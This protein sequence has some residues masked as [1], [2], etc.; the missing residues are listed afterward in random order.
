MNKVSLQRVFGQ[1]FLVVFSLALFS[2]SNASG[3]YEAASRQSYPTVRFVANMQTDMAAVPEEISQ[4][5]SRSAGAGAAYDGLSRSAMPEVEISETGAQ[6]YVEAVCG[7]DRRFVYGVDSTLEIG[8]NSGRTWNVTCGIGTIGT[9]P[10]DATKTIAT[11][12]LMSSVA[13]N[14]PIPEDNPIFSQ[15][16]ALTPSTDGSGDVL[17]EVNVPASGYKVLTYC[18][19]SPELTHNTTSSPLPS[20]SEDNKK[21]VLQANDVTSGTYEVVFRI[22]DTSGVLVYCTTQTINVFDHMTTKV[23]RPDGSSAISDAGVFKVDASVITAFVDNTIYVG[24]TGL[25]LD[26]SDDNAGTAFTPLKKLNTA[27]EKIK[28]Y[29]NAKDYRIYISGTIDEP[30][31]IVAGIDTTKAASITIEGYNGLGADGMPQD[32]ILGQSIG[33]SFS[34]TAFMSISARAPIITQNILFT[35]S[36]SVGAGDR[37]RALWLQSNANVTLGPGTVISGFNAG[38]SYDSDCKYN[39]G[40]VC[41]LAGAKLTVKGAVISRNT[42]YAGGGIYIKGNG[43]VEIN[44]SGSKITDNHALYGGGIGVENAE[45]NI[46]KTTISGNKADLDKDYDHGG[47]LTLGVG[48]DVTLGS[49]VV[50]QGNTARFGG[51]VD[52]DGATLTLDGGQ[53]N[54]NHAVGQ[55]N[56]SHGVIEDGDDS[57]GGCG[58]GIYFGGT[59]CSVNVYRG[60]I[61]GNTAANLGGGIYFDGNQFVDEDMH[62]LLHVTGGTIEN[63]KATNGGGAIYIYPPNAGE[64][65]DNTLTFN[66]GGSAYIPYGVNGAE[67]A[68]KN[69]IF[70]DGPN[71]ETY[72][73]ITLQSALTKHSKNKPIAIR[74]NEDIEVG[75]NPKRGLAVVQASSSMESQK[76][77]FK[78]YSEDWKLKLSSDKTALRLDA[79]IYVAGLTSHPYCGV[80]GDDDTGN[81]TKTAPFETIENG[82]CSVMDDFNA[83]YTI[84]IDGAVVGAQ[85]IPDTALA[86]SITL[87]GANGDNNVDKIGSVTGRPVL[88][89]N[90]TADVTIKDLQIHAANNTNGHGGDICSATANTLTLSSGARLERSWVLNEEC[91]GAGVYKYTGKLVMEDGAIIQNGLLNPTEDVVC[92]GAGI[93]LKK[94]NFV[95]TGGKIEGNQNHTVG[96][97]GGIYFDA[98]GA[99]VSIRISGGEITKNQAKYGAGIYMNGGK[100][101]MSGG[102]IHQNARYMGQDNSCGGGI[103]VDGGA[104]IYLY[105]KA[106]IGRTDISSAPTTLSIN[107]SNYAHF[108]GGIYVEKGNVWL[109]YKDTNQPE[110]FEEV[111]EGVLGGIIGNYADAHGGGIYIDG[112][113]DGNYV[114]VADGQISYN[115]AKS[116]SGFGGGIFIPVSGEEYV[117]L[118]GG[119]LKGNSAYQGG[120]IYNGTMTGSLKIGGDAFIQ[121]MDGAGKN[122]IYLNNNNGPINITSALN[123]HDTSKKINV[124]VQE[125]NFGSGKTLVSADFAMSDE[126]LGAFQ[127]FF[128]NSDTEALVAANKKSIFIN[129]PIYV[130]GT[131]YDSSITQAGVPDGNGSRDYP[132]D[133][134]TAAFNLLTN[135][136]AYYNI[137]VNGKLMGT[138]VLHDDRYAESVLLEGVQT[139]HNADG[140]PKDTLDADQSSY[141]ENGTTLKINT[142]T[143]FTIKNL[144]VTG[145]KGIYGGGVYVKSGATLVLDTDAHVVGNSSQ[146]SAYLGD[147]GG[148]YNEGTLIMKGGLVNNNIATRFGGGVYSTGNIYVYGDTVIGDE[149]KKNV[150]P[151]NNDDFGNRAKR[152]GGI[153]CIGDSNNLR[154]IYLGYD[155]NGEK[156]AWNG[157]IYHNLANGGENNYWG[158]GLYIHYFEL[159][160]DSGTISGN[161]SQGVMYEGEDRIYSEISGG[162]ITKNKYNDTSSHGAGL[163]FHRGDLE[164]SG[165]KIKGNFMNDEGNGSDIQIDSGVWHYKRKSFAISGSA[166]LGIVQLG[167][168]HNSDGAE[169][170]RVTGALEPPADAG[171]VTATIN[172]YENT[173]TLSS[174]FM[175]GD[176]LL[177]GYDGYTLTTQDVQKIHLTGLPWEI[178]KDASDSNLYVVDRPIYVSGTGHSTA[179]GNGDDDF[180]DG[181]KARPFASIYRATREMTITNSP[182]TVMIDGTLQAQNIPEDVDVEGTAYKPGSIKLVGLNGV[183]SHGIPQDAIDA[184]GENCTALTVNGVVLPLEIANLKITGGNSSNSNWAGGIYVGAKERPSGS[185]SSSDL[186]L[187]DGV[188]ITGNTAT[189][190]GSAGGVYCTESTLYFYG[191]EISSN[192]GSHAV[193]VKYDF[194]VKGS[195][196]VPDNGDG[197]DVY[198]NYSS[199]KI[200]PMA[201]LTKHNSTDKKMRVTISPDRYTADY[202]LMEKHI[203][204]EPVSIPSECGKFTVGDGSSYGDFVI[205]GLGKLVSSYIGSKVPGSVLEVGDVVFTD[206]SASPY[207]SVTSAQQASAVAVIFYRGTACS[208]D[209]K[210]RALGVGLVQ[211]SG[212]SWCSGSAKGYG[213]SIDSTTC[214][215]DQEAAG[216]ATTFEDAV[217]RNGK[218][219][220]DQLNSTLSSLPGGSDTY[221]GATKYTANYFASVYRDAATNITSSAYIN[222]WYLPSAAELFQIYKNKATVNAA[223]SACGGTPFD[224]AYLTSSQHASNASMIMYLDF[225]G[226]SQIFYGVDKT[227]TT[228]KTCAI[229]EF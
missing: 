57:N 226:T 34:D 9:D 136:D 31:M 119:S 215:P 71:N 130:A 222:D 95:M 102:V 162:L 87:Q 110:D 191:G 8:L 98:G 167:K 224:G 44:I 170:I 164:I 204:N 189:G 18:A 96:R 221:D 22:L 208:N 142:A 83:D 117:V 73:K 134:L 99:D 203:G 100:L 199:P 155:E 157:G 60:S 120:A 53:I 207:T 54:E 123:N 94:A 16:F 35:K 56:T 75:G 93:Y 216:S 17:L 40:G 121:A 111:V 165:G 175:R 180:G 132:F 151:E 125:S 29:G 159:K 195:A 68:G 196:Y 90:S 181:S 67:G 82:A 108:G 217:D 76:D 70:F 89:I 185:R 66:L 190:A 4:L 38:D 20:D 50:V 116:A 229:H 112:T 46:T 11:T 114:Y 26:P 104:N 201:P 103:Y 161:K 91:G 218:D 14:F 6:Y 205:N 213:V 194:F 156:T 49:G 106:L 27:F 126:L 64:S 122:D 171:G 220:Y 2:C 158:G 63:N 176:G 3:G 43:S 188:L 219:N 7:T 139:T 19:D 86:A 59:A 77:S 115:G 214:A 211:A 127:F 45:V 12:V 55:K 131:G 198:L 149:S 153:Y 81:G 212:K 92:H 69:D 61:S 148:I 174:G 209:G 144:K 1:V 166:S 36:S 42:A 228:K 37:S 210:T 177:Q 25:G 150:V 202:K 146:Q 147:G 133:S 129:K 206:G 41:V 145:G 124:R 74:I 79:P 58:G 13:Q 85:E 223:L 80:A 107:V 118:T 88:T 105:G 192:T 109:G 52:M 15:T 28:E 187:M 137:R 186:Q 184:T 97:G 33:S 182:Y 197:C 23:W 227:L 84:L 172:I 32:K 48:A 128:T 168:Y 163:Y 179:T 140:S 138:C 169:I 10:E 101:Y 51:G 152:G 65:A 72:A 47:G 183:D 30:N 178:I 173:S 200:K 160:M 141:S 24:A 62:H 39:G 154:K 193:Y 113:Y 143:K 225:G 5:V 78:L 135:P 21:K